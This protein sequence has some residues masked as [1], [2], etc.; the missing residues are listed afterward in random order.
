METVTENTWTCCWKDTGTEDAVASTASLSLRRDSRRVDNSV[1]GGG[2]VC[3][4][5]WL[6]NW[7][8]DVGGFFVASAEAL[9]GRDAKASIKFSACR[10]Q[11]SIH[12]PL[13]RSK[14]FFCSL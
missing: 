1:A 10:A 14:Y 12:R 8:R 4:V 5:L 13:I 6:G 7:R 3:P 2:P 11:N 9:V